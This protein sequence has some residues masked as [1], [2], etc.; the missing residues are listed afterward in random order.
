[1][2]L[3]NYLPRATILEARAFLL[4]HLVRDGFVVPFPGGRQAALPISSAAPSFSLSSSSDEESTDADVLH[5]SLPAAKRARVVKESPCTAVLPPNE[6][7]HPQAAHAHAPNPDPGHYEWAASTAAVAVNPTVSPQY[8]SRPDL[9]AAS[10]VMAV[11]E[12]ARLWQLADDLTSTTTATSTNHNNHNNHNATAAGTGTGAGHETSPSLASDP[13]VRTTAFK[14]VR[15]V[16]PEQYA[17]PPPCF[18]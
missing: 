15:A 8:L 13:R 12:H 2:L 6:S 5:S 1:M 18:F 9:H 7:T 11:L 16:P 17:P 14:W 3:R 10:P 4:T